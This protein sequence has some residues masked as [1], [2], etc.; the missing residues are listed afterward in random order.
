[1]T[2]ST[3][4]AI[5]I[6]LAAARPA[7][8]DKN[9]Y[10]V[11]TTGMQLNTTG[12]KNYPGAD[13][14]R[15]TTVGVP[16]LGV[17]LWGDRK[18]PVTLGIQFD[19]MSL[20]GYLSDP[21]VMPMFGSDVGITFPLAGGRIGLG[22]VIDTLHIKHPMLAFGD[23]TADLGGQLRYTHPIADVVHLGL[24][25][26]VVATGGKSGHDKGGAF[27]V[28]VEVLYKL[29][30]R[31]SVF[32]S[33][34]EDIRTYKDTTIPHGEFSLVSSMFRFGIALHNLGPFGSNDFR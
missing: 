8:A 30:H 17:R 10:A 2:H 20:A 6:L 1:M 9:R 27:G 16:T 21:H 7:A 14:D 24:M 4:I 22:G 23:Y 31:L 33:F 5:V 25:T 15:F 28:Q 26:Q 3:R 29:S 18:L 13:P 34:Q 32:A 19:V 11:I 12:V